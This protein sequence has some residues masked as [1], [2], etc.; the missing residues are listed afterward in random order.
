MSQREQK[1]LVP[2]NVERMIA[3]KPG[4]PIEELERELGIT[5]AIKLAS[6]E[7]PFG[8]SPKV[9]AAMRAAVE[10][11]RFYPDGA[12]HEA[13]SAI[14][15]FLSRPTEEV[16]IGNGS[17]ELIDLICR[18]FAA[19][20]D[21]MVFGKPSFVCYWLGATA[22]NVDYTEVPLIE[23]LAW[24]VQ[25]MLDAVTPRTKILFLANPNN[26]TGAH[27]SEDEL[28]HLLSSLPEDVVA[29]LDEAYFEFATADDY[30]TALKH[31]HLHE[32]TLVLRTLSKAYGLAGMRVGYA[33]GPAALVG[34]LHRMRAPFNVNL[35]A[36]AAVAPA[37]EDQAWVQRYVDFNAEERVRVAAALREL[38]LR[39]APSQGNF[40]LVDFGRP[41]RDVYDV[42]LRRGVITRPMP[43][44]IDT[45]LRIS[46]GTREENDRMLSAGAEEVRGR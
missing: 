4:K 7:N 3:Y 46:L 27:I 15:R 33:T 12:G 10:D 24:D 35:V 8:P 6:N 44:P 37:L 41:G 42:L 19:P 22:T 32:R 29:V 39:P 13:R 36:Q 25:A 38:G 9:L 18:T 21:H 26:P 20:G 2:P 5:G 40:L 16:V 14:A 34:Y 45:W 30:A 23:N 11:V 17:N 31:L 1:P 28:V 43:A